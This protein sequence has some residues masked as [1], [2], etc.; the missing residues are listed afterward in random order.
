MKNLK[1]KILCRN[2]KQLFAPHFEYET[3]PF[4]LIILNITSSKISKPPKCF[5]NRPK[6]KSSWPRI[7]QGEENWS[8]HLLTHLILIISMQI[9]CIQTHLLSVG[10]I[11]NFRP[12]ATKMP[13]R[14]ELHTHMCLPN[15][16]LRERFSVFHAMY[17]YL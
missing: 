13:A 14:Y 16:I 7:S 11:L 3:V 15:W 9:Q 1:I 12:R 8:K 17:V 5:Q 10:E 6:T 2:P 4:D